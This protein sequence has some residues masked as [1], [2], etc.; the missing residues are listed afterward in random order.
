M[1][2]ACLNP[3]GLN[4]RGLSVLPVA[5]LPCSSTGEMMKGLTVRVLL[6]VYE[7]LWAEL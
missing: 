2:M 4:P 3:L 5:L 7:L 6:E 1:W